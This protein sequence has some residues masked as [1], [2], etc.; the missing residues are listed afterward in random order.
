[1]RRQLTIR[2]IS[3]SL[4]LAVVAGGAQA[5]VT[6]VGVAQS[7]AADSTKEVRPFW[8]GSSV[9]YGQS[10][11]VM[12]L[13]RSAQPFYNPVWVHRVGLFPE[14][15]AGDQLTFRGR[16]FLA[17]ELTLSDVT[18]HRH[19]V[20]LSDI[21]LDSIWSGWQ[22]KVTGIRVNA[23]VRVTLPTSRVSQAQTRL[24]TLGPAVNLMRSFAVRS[25]LTFIYS[26][27]FTWRA[28]RLPTRQ[29][30][31]PALVTCVD[32]RSL[33]CL[34]SYSSGVRNATFDLLHGP[35]VS[36]SPHD[37]VN[38]AAV[39]MMQRAWLPPLSAVPPELQGSTQL[40]SRA[41]VPTR[42][43]IFFSL[44]ATWQAFRAVGFTFSAWTFSGQLGEDG[45]YQ[46]PLFNRNTTFALDAILDFEQLIEAT[47]KKEKS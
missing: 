32:V 42:D 1:M 26:A 11:G 31:G 40:D 2:Q 17:Q 20:E 4:V 27:R 12:S 41:D 39:F 9:S 46:F 16:L 44:S 36:F 43:A 47:R 38:L 29:N 14:V 5:Q 6:P 34:D 22:E 30:S 45:R 24:F 28:N 18:T 15:H 35:V 33:E 19:E 23:D 7:G 37:K 8:R 25:G 10:L 13:S 21:W 3:F